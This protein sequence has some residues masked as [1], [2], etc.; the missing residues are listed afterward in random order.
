MIVETI[1]LDHAATTPLHKEVLDVM[2]PVAEEVFGN[3][4]S[5][6]SYGRKARQ[7]L[8]EARRTMARSI[9]ADEKEIYFTSGGTEA[10]NMAFIGTALENRKKGNHIITTNQEHHAIYRSAEY[11]EQLGFDVTY[12]P[13]YENGLISLDDLKEALTEKTILVSVMYVNNETGVI[14]PIPEIGEMLQ[15]HQAFFHTDAVQAYG[16][17]DINVKEMH[18]DLLSTSAHKIN[19]PKG[20]GFL[21]ASEH[22]PVS[23]LTFGGEQERKRRAG[24]ENVVNVKGFQK[25]VEIMNETRKENREKYT[26]LKEQFLE[27]LKEKNVDFD[28]NGDPSRTIS[29]IVNI[30]FPGINVETMLTNLDLSGIAASSGS[31]CTAGTVDPSHVLVAMYGKNDERINQSIR[32]SFGLNNTVENIREA[33]IRIAQIIHR[34]KGKRR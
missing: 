30:S 29:S 8:D 27:I 21:Y 26:I 4:S 19:G 20:I 9:S 34:L 10:D 17:L 1:Y 13:I 12:L 25:A 3:P 14:Q 6:H 11:L 32:F 24:T 22:V 2:I 31:A 16:L 7:I 5:I 15:E 23:S 33:A 18:I 28:T